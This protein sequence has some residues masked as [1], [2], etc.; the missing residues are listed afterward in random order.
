MSVRLERTG[1]ESDQ[2]HVFVPRRLNRWE[3]LPNMLVARTKFGACACGGTTAKGGGGA[4]GG[5]TGVGAGVGV[6]D[7]IF[8]CGGYNSKLLGKTNAKG[9]L[10]TVEL[11]EPR[12]VRRL[13]SLLWP[14]RLSVGLSVCCPGLQ[15]WAT[16]TTVAPPTPVAY[17]LACLASQLAIFLPRKQTNRQTDKQTNRQTDKQTNKLTN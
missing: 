7:K 17:G 12:C 10:D 15:P 11:Y 8:V 4:G 6:P 2:A 16:T 3:V 9:I 14:G 5:M 13:C 1:I